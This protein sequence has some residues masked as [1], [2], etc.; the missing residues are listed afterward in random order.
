V[1]V[2]GLVG[3]GAYDVSVLK[4]LLQRLRP[5]VRDVETRQCGN[6]ARVTTT[7]RN[8]LRGFRYANNGVPVDKAIVVRDAHGLT[9]REILNRFASGFDPN[10]YPFPVEFAAIVP[11]LEAWL[12]ADHN[13]LA[14]LSAERGQQTV[15]T[16]LNFP[17][18]QIPDPKTRLGE[19]L[20]RPGVPYTEAAAMRLAELMDIQKIEQLCP[21]FTLFKRAALNC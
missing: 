7:F 21:S 4:I 6:D 2:F 17:P 3:A 18:E 20:G 5:D 14:S 19:L 12:L 13:G 9:Q 11:E 15:Y 8:V 1:P 16:P 10:S